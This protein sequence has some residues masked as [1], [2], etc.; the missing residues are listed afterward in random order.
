[1]LPP[2]SAAADGHPHYREAYPVRIVEN[3]TVHMLIDLRSTLRSDME[4]T[5]VILI[6]SALSVDTSAVYFS[7]GKR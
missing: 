3:R 2:E 7:S 5:L 6:E 1:M 4:Y